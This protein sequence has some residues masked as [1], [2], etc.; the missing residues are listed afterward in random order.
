MVTYADIA[1]KAGVAAS[2]V[3]RALRGSSAVSPETREHV[4]KIAEELGYRM[5]RLQ[6]SKSESLI[7]IACPQPWVF[8]QGSYAS[9]IVAGVMKV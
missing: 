6:S 9:R 2:T 1:K 3:S 4:R 5:E 7:G 8:L